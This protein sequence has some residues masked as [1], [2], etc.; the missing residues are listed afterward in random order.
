M[1]CQKRSTW[2][3]DSFA[4]TKWVFIFGKERAAFPLIQGADAGPGGEWPESSTHH[5]KAT[6]SGIVIQSNRPLLPS[7]SLMASV[8]SYCRVITII[9]SVGFY[10]PVKLAA[11]LLFANRL[12]NKSPRKDAGWPGSKDLQRRWC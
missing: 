6:G 3:R 7:G 12:Q 2:A 5:S 11:F 9:I 4:Q 8:P 1:P 10:A